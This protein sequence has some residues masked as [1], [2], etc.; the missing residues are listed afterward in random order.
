MIPNALLAQCDV[1]TV[2]L[3]TVLLIACGRMVRG[4]ATFAQVGAR[5]FRTIAAGNGRREDGAPPAF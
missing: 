3:M 1:M 4:G 2:V 5:C